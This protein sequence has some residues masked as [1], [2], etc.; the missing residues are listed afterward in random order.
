MSEMK[1]HQAALFQIKVNSTAKLG[2]LAA[3]PFRLRKSQFLL[4]S[5]GVKKLEIISGAEC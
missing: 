4:K 1:S 5:W 3:V 2:V